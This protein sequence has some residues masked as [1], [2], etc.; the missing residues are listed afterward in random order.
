MLTQWDFNHLILC[1]F[2]GGWRGGGG[3]D[4]YLLIHNLIPIEY[5]VEKGS[6]CGLF[7]TCLD[8]G[9]TAFIIELQGS[10]LI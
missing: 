10:T 1:F 9:A 5:R 6:G 3:I 7:G 2:F 8:V 4:C